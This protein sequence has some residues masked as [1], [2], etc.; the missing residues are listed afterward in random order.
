LGALGAA[1][2]IIIFYQSF[3]NLGWS[4]GNYAGSDAA[5]FIF[6]GILLVGVIIAVSV[7][8]SSDNPRGGGAI[9]LPGIGWGGPTTSGRGRH[10]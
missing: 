2:G 9:M 1:I 6:M 7:S 8:K 10:S 4:I 5:A 3:G